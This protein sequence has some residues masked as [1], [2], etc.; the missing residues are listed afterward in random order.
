[1]NQAFVRRLAKLTN[2]DHHNKLL[3][4]HRGIEKEALRICPSG[5]LADTPHP[6]ALGS[7]LSHSAITTDFAESLLEFIT[8]VSSDIDTALNH[9]ADAHKY[10]LD[11]MG[12]ELL[13]PMSM[14]C[15]VNPE[16]PIQLAQ[17]GSSN[18]GQMKT[19][20]RRGLHNRYGSLMQVISGVHYNFSLSDAFWR[21]WQTVLGEQHTPLQTFK[22]TEY[23]GL[24]RNY[25][26]YA[27]LVPFLFGASPAICRS[28]L[29]D[30][31]TDIPFKKAARGTLYLPYGTSLR[32]SDLGYTNSEQSKLDICHNNLESYIASVLNAAA[33]PSAEFAKIGIKVEG[34][35]QQLNSNLIQIENELYAPIRPKRVT[36]SGETP[37]QALARGG[38]EYIEVRSLDVDPFSPIGIQRETAAFIDLL[39]VYCL[40]DESPERD[41]ADLHRA[42]RNLITS[43][44]EGRKPDV[45]LQ[46]RDGEMPLTEW[47]RQILNELQP[48][49]K[50]MDEELEQPVYQAALATQMSKMDNPSLTPSAKIVDTITQQEVD[51]GALGLS[52]ARQYRQ[53][54]ARRDYADVPL[55]QWQAM[56]E[57]SLLKQAE[58]E[59]SD[60]VTLDAFLQDYFKVNY[61]RE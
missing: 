23:L 19:I 5:E 55:V 13:W 28:F 54:M 46:R 53:Q 26:R 15:F 35:Y 51:N 10:A 41:E 61:G 47:G 24:I 16:K 43:A 58:E 18:I 30:R 2:S 42:Q 14:P 60:S 11:Q 8:P 50:M 44:L 31:Q 39:L 25:Y 48:L 3:P 12:E 21:H 56:A 1:M 34:V 33:T 38:I 20:Y 6:H 17:Y 45:M 36:R 40:V 4:I 59:A 7:A 52:L 22:S 29:Q 49:A 37:S 27:W 57:Q 9:L 32:L